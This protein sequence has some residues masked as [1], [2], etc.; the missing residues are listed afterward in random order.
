MILKSLNQSAQYSR[1]RQDKKVGM[2]A[3]FI[4]NSEKTLAIVFSVDLSSFSAAD[5][6]SAMY[7]CEHRNQ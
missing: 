6:I 4:Q 2:T 3:L 5:F 1:K 7:L